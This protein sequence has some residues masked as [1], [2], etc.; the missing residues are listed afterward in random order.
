MPNS[1]RTLGDFDKLRCTMM[2]SYRSSSPAGTKWSGHRHNLCVVWLM[3]KGYVDITTELGTQRVH[4]G[5]WVIQMPGLY[6]EQAFSDDAEIMSLRFR[7]LWETGRPLFKSSRLLTAPRLRFKQLQESA[8]SF[9]ALLPQEMQPAPTYKHVKS[10]FVT[11]PARAWLIQSAQSAFL[12]D[13]YEAALELG[14]EP[15]D[16]FSGDS[17]VDEM[18]DILSAN[19]RKNN[20][21][22]QHF[23]EAVGLSR[24]Q[25]DRLFAKYLNSS[26]KAEFDNMRVQYALEQLWKG[27]RAIKQIAFELGFKSASQFA[28]WFHRL[29]GRNPK[30]V[31]REGHVAV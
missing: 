2:M 9:I 21:P 20:V 27:R 25:I 15:L 12:S 5:T 29:D 19:L 30:E 4:A 24:A 26:P 22:Y 14:Y 18:V 6:L 13:W 31:R 10:T 11:N 16:E 17:R 28:K 23:Q 8:R 1:D 3:E 7:V